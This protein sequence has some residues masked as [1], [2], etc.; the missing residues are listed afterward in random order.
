MRY[1][2]EPPGEE[3]QTRA[4]RG[5]DFRRNYHFDP[6]KSYFSPFQYYSYKQSLF[7]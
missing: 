5:D 1:F 7:S 4:E 3:K 2:D 6:A